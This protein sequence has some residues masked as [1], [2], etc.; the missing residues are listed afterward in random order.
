MSG[1]HFKCRVFFYC[2][3]FRVLHFIPS[4]CKH[5]FRHPKITLRYAA[6]SYQYRCIPTFY[7]QWAFGRHHIARC[8]ASTGCHCYLS[9]THTPVGV[10]SHL[11]ISRTLRSKYIFIVFNGTN[12]ILTY[13][14]ASLF[15]I[16][17]I[18]QYKISRSS[19]GAGQSGLCL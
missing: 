7:S 4:G 13:P 8:N 2:L 9:G 6:I 5:I 19:S 16:P 12:R 10:H 3:G 15:F 18:T 17:S 1:V 14:V 11:I